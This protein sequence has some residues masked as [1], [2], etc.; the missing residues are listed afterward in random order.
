MEWKGVSVIDMCL[1]EMV[2]KM[3]FQSAWLSM[4]WGQ[5]AQ[6]LAMVVEGFAEILPSLI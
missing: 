3:E 1:M 6:A 2:S 5:R 4:E